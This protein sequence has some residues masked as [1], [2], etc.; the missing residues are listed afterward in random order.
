MKALALALCALATPAL[1]EAPDTAQLQVQG[2]LVV[3]PCSPKFP[4]TQEIKLG[5]VNLNRLSQGNVP[6]T[7][8]TLGFDCRPG[9]Q[10]S[11]SLAAGLGSADSQTL[12]TDRAGLGLRVLGEEGLVS[13]VLNQPRLFQAGDGPVTLSVRVKPVVVGALPEPGAFSATLLMQ[14]LYL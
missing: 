5:E 6:V 13:W 11:V 1:A 8:V 7:E 9:S 4:S 14:V 10:L 2:R 3:P 12:L